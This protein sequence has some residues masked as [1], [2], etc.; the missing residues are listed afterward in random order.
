MT[1][2]MELLFHSSVEVLYTDKLEW[3]H[4]LLTEPKKKRKQQ[5]WFG[6]FMLIANNSIFKSIM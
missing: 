1:N 3:N 4:L 2:E 6:I 5:K